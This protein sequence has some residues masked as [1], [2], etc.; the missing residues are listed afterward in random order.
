[1][2]KPTR[3][4]ENMINDADV[5]VIGAGGG[6]AVVAKELCEKG[7]KVLLLEAG[8]WYGNKKWPNPNAEH[9]AISSSEY[10]D[11]SIGT[12]RES[13]TDLENDMNDL[14]NGKFRWGCANRTQG[15]WKRNIANEGYAWQTAGVG[16]S[17]LHYFGNSPR[18]FPS[19]VDDIWPIPYNELIPYYEK[20]EETLPVLD[21]PATAKEN[22]FYYGAQK[23]NWNLLTD[24]NVTQPGYRPQPN[25]ILLRNYP[26]NIPNYDSEKDG[27]YGCIFRGEC[28]NGCHIGP[29]VQAVA[30][31]ATF[32]SYVPPALSTGNIEVRPN[33]F[34]IKV[35]TEKDNQQ[36]IHAV[37]VI[38]RDTWTGELFEVRADVVVMAGGGIET[39]RLWLNSELPQNPWVGKGL[40]NHWFDN[41]TG[42]YD[43][44]VL[45]DILG[46]S[47]ISPFVGQN[48]AARFDY[49]G[50]GVIQ[51]YGMS[52]GLYSS[53]IYAASDKGSY[54]GNGTNT[55]APWDIEGAVVG[56]KLK[57]FMRDYSRTLS[58]LIFIDDEVNQRNEVTLDYNQKD[59][60]GFIPKIRYYPSENDRI[61]RDKLAVIAADILRKAGAKTIIRSNWSPDIFIHIQCTM[62]M[63][64]VTDTNC[65]AKQVKRLF[66]ADNSVLYNA[67]GGPNPTLTTQALATRTAEKIKNEYF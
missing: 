60:N 61:K 5:I 20:V 35:L 33:A 52:P 15:P 12:L 41:V 2:V 22:L 11:L 3:L 53:T 57:E 40:I 34:V 66:I 37:G 18:A 4:E 23:A 36:G 48:A 32:V 19:T 49:P 62:R 21:A 6:G 63:G 44:K 56:E 45:M 1:M 24:K 17:T 64:F 58:L 39:P 27:P 55:N 16:G 25:A 31:R 50:L 67:I 65:E 59:E 30:K 8:P 10:D 7:I 51:T 26:I 54:K 38:Y 29:V 42:I 28:V 13:F 47:N 46:S 9:G 43:E 14:V